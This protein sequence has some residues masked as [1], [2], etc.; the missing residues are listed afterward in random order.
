MLPIYIAEWPLWSF[1]R[2]QFLI[3]INSIKSLLLS[4]WLCCYI[5]RSLDRSEY[6]CF[7]IVLD[8]RLPCQTANSVLINFCLPK[9]EKLVKAI[10]VK[11]LHTIATACIFSKLY[12]RR[13]KE[14]GY[15]SRTHPASRHRSSVSCQD[16]HRLIY[17]PSYGL[18]LGCT[19]FS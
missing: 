7:Y 1:G 8:N 18:G 2:Q 13:I 6:F 19:N 10:T 12:G 5:Q 15:H 4:L 17:N 16:L 11:T 9:V 14:R 3:T